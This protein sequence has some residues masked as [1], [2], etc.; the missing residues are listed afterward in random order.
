MPTIATQDGDPA[1]RNQIIDPFYRGEAV[2][3]PFTG[4]FDS[5][6]TAWAV[7]FTLVPSSG[8]A[9]EVTSPTVTA[10]VTDNGDGTWDATFTVPLTHAQTDLLATGEAGWQFD[11]TDSGS[12]WLLGEGTVEILEPRA[13]LGA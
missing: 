13:D 11:R 12:E 3:Y 7:R 2:S 9:V 8:D 4:T 1:S 5:D 10:S 6:P